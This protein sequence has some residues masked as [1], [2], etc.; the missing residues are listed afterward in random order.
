[1]LSPILSQF[2]PIPIHKTY[3]LIHFNI[4]P[5]SVSQSFK[6]SKGFPTRL[7][8]TDKH[9]QLEVYHEIGE[10][11]I[12]RTEQQRGFTELNV[13]EGL[14]RL[15]MFLQSTLHTRVK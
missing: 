10:V 15:E 13:M 5:I 1:M 8:H 4:F 2:N 11:E 12:E 9:I 7:I 6:L 3:L 14:R